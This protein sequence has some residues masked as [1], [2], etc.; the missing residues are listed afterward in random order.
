LNGVW[1]RQNDSCAHSIAISTDASGSQ[2]KI[3]GAQG[4]VSSGEIVTVDPDKRVIFT[5]NS[6]GTAVDPHAQWEYHPNGGQLTVIDKDGTPTTFVHCAGR[7][8]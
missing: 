2:I 7:P 5:R 1:G 3:R 4:Y 8:A 6:S